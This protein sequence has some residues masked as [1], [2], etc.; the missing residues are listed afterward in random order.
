MLIVAR[1][2]C[3]DVDCW[4]VCLSDGCCLFLMWFVA[5]RFLS[6]ACCSLWSV[7]CWLCLVLVVCR[8]LLAVGSCLLIYV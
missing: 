5:C 2:L 8:L 7:A 6:V 3:V 1:C 4:L